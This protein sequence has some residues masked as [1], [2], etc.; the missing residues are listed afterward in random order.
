MKNVIKRLKLF[1][2]IGMIVIPAFVK[3]QPPFDPGVTDAPFDGGVSLLVAAGIGYGL[4]KVYNKKKAGK[5]SSVIE[6]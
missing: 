6:K 4:K 2:V 3:A 5:D 1:L